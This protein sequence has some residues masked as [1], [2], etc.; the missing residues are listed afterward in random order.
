MQ[1]IA[2]DHANS[3]GLGGDK[4]V[5]DYGAVWMM[6]RMY[7][8]LSRPIA[9]GDELRLTTWHRGADKTAVVN[10]DFDIFAG[11]E[12]IGEAVIS[13]VIVDVALRKLVKPLALTIVAD[14]P[15]PCVVKD[16]VPGKIKPPEYMTQE[17]T[18]IVRYSDTD[19]NGHMNNTKYVDIA[20]DAVQYEKLTGKFIS[21]VQINYMQECFPGEELM[22]SRG[23]QDGLE[24][25]RGADKEGKV[26]FDV[27]LRIEDIPE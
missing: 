22:I 18:R 15:V 25:V 23:E 27:G 6:A 1:N 8:R 24:Y 10:R 2:T 20:C 13:W 4:M 5:A 9:N 12:R 11:D 21:E 19:L 7:V 16:I 14:S 26:R 3:F 17:M